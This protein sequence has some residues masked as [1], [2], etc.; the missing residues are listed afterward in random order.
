MNGYHLLGDP[1]PPHL[2]LPLS[3]LDVDM[4]AAEER[5]YMLLLRRSFLSACRP[6]WADGEGR[7]FVLYTIRELA[8]DLHRS[9]SCVKKAL[10]R[11]EAL[12]LIERRSQGTGKANRVY[13]KLPSDVEAEEVCADTMCS[14]AGDTTCSRA[15]DTACSRA[16]DTEVTPSYLYGAIYTELSDRS[17][18]RPPARPRRKRSL[19]SRLGRG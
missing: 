6:G 18:P 16:G 19:F 12:D 13:V 10:N 17:D 8:V 3:L 5:V 4:T 7:V 14:R 9:V 1:V 11:L 2:T 15:A